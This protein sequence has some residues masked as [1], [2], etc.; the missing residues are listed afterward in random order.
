MSSVDDTSID[1]PIDEDFSA[2]KLNEAEARK[3]DEETG[4]DNDENSPSLLHPT[5][6]RGRPAAC[7]KSFRRRGMRRHRFSSPFSS[8]LEIE[9]NEDSDYSNYTPSKAH[10]ILKPRLASS[11]SIDLEKDTNDDKI[12]FADER[13]RMTVIFEQQSWEGE[14]IDERDSKQGRGRPRKQYLVRWKS[15]WVDGG[16]LIAPTLMQNWRKERVSKGGH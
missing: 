10:N 12:E 14:I 15:S 16:R 3:E 13:S 9:T 1:Q 11:R 4:R 5:K 8:D 6:K 7:E 2:T